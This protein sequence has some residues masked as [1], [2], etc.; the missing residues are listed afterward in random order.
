MNRICLIF[1]FLS[2]LIT[3]NVNALPIDDNGP[4]PDVPGP[5]N[6]PE[7]QDP[8][9]DQLLDPRCALNATGTV[10]ASPG[11]I[12]LDQSVTLSWSAQLPVEYCDGAYLTLNGQSVL[13]EGSMVIKAMYSGYYRL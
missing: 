12:K 8:T 11:Q 10:F 3:V 7:G 2:S 9:N 1:L 6:Q 5:Q 13:A 4:P